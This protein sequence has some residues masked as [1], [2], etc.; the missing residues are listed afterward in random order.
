M[1]TDFDPG[2]HDDEGV[3]PELAPLDLADKPDGPAAAVM[4]ASGLGVFTLG[5]MTTLAVING[6]VKSF[7]EWFQFDQGVGALAGKSTVAVLVFFVAWLVLYLIWR[8]KDV[9]LKTSF[10]IGLGL[11]ILGVIGTFPPFFEWFE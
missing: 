7:L 4:I 1:I 10:Y 2:R 8:E 3:A 11:G 9:V 5:L 6:S